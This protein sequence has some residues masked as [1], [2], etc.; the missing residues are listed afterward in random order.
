M[1][2]IFTCLILLVASQNCASGI[3]N[4]NGVTTVGDNQA[5]TFT[6]A[7]GGLI[8]LH[9]SVTSPSLSTPSAS[10]YAWSIQPSSPIAS[11]SRL[12]VGQV[13]VSNQNFNC[14][15][16]GD[17][18]N[19]NVGSPAPY[20]LGGYGP[21]TIDA[22]FKPS[23]KLQCTNTIF[24][25][26][27]PSSWIETCWT[28]AEPTTTTLATASSLTASTSS[29]SGSATPAPTVATLYSGYYYV[30]VNRNCTVDLC[31]ACLDPSIT[32]LEM[33]HP[34]GAID[35]IDSPYVWARINIM[36]NYTA[37]FFGYLFITLLSPFF[38]VFL[39]LRIKSRRMIRR[40]RCTEDQQYA[41]LRYLVLTVSARDGQSALQRPQEPL[42]QRH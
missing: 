34:A 15:N 3:V 7:A 33:T 1:L 18:G 32:E 25:C 17:R 2:I 8:C 31:G 37:S 41:A 28:Q 21:I 6:L 11:N 23:I 4:Q 20:A 16:F 30:T 19:L 40:S 5:T 13:P 39:V 36:P 12:F 35:T 26:S 24:S 9:S 27:F 10:K 38:I 42:E 14:N 29:S 22:N